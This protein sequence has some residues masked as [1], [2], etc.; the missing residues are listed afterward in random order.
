MELTPAERLH[1]HLLLYYPYLRIKDVSLSNTP[2]FLQYENGLIDIRGASYGTGGH[3]LRLWNELHQHFAHHVDVIKR[4]YGQPTIVLWN[5]MVF[6]LDQ[7][8]TYRLKEERRPHR[9]RERTANMV[10]GN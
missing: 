9:D 5:G 4:K 8:K 7:A 2:G 3:P 1:V 6:H 10:N